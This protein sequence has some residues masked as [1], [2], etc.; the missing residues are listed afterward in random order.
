MPCPVSISTPLGSFGVA[1]YA[2]N[3]GYGW[4]THPVS[5]ERKFH[6]GIDMAAPEGEAVRSVAPGTVSSSRYSSTYGNIV[7]IVHNNGYQSLY[8]HMRSRAVNKGD[9]VKAGDLIGEVGHTGTATGNHL[10]FEM[11]SPDGQN[12]D[13]T[14]C[15]QYSTHVRTYGNQQSKFP[16]WLPYAIG[17]GLLVTGIVIA[18]TRDKNK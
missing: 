4:R 16:T 13:P 7:E 17:G 15:Y 8:A 10:H 6:Y 5:G 3:S 1:K 9:Q 18:A 2:I 14:Q 11:A 12:I